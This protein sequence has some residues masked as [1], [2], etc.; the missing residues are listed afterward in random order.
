VTTVS[1]QLD[2]YGAWLHVVTR[3]KDWRR[4]RKEINREVPKR[5]TSFGLACR[6]HGRDGSTHLLV[7]IDVKKVGDAGLVELCAHEAAHAAVMLFDQ[8]GERVT[9][10]SEPYAYL[11][12]W[13]TSFIWQHARGNGKPAS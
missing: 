6:T 5:V 7:F 4:L 11:C 9:W 1:H 2:V 12:G 3:K 8:I 13:L 10:K